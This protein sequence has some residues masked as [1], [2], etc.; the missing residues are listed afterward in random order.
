MSG[1]DYKTAAR[2]TL[3]LLP[4]DKVKVAFNI[5]E[6]LRD[7]GTRAESELDVTHDWLKCFTNM[8]KEELLAELLTAIADASS[9][10]NWSRIQAV[11]EEWEETSEILSDEQLITGIRESE[12]QIENGE[13][14]AWETA[15]R[16]LSSG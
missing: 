16:K 7:V 12:E 15:K 10:G 5:L 3:D 6:Y 14:I 4:D 2:K 9:S 11:I 1:T 13:V 8:E